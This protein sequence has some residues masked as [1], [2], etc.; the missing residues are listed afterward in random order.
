MLIF[1]VLFCEWLL[2]AAC[3]RNADNMMILINKIASFIKLWI[4]M[5][6]STL[7]KTRKLINFKRKEKIHLGV[8]VCEGES[9]LFKSNFNTNNP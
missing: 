8:C 9:F 2:F 3:N 7:N 5:F 6:D 1:F 4:K